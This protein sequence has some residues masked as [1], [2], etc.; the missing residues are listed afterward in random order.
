MFYIVSHD[1][2][3]WHADDRRFKSKFEAIRHIQQ[4]RGCEGRI[5]WISRDRVEVHFDD[6]SRFVSLAK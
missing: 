3:L 1:G 6:Q 2:A 5:V 4:V